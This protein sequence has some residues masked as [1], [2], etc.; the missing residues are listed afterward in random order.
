MHVDGFDKVLIGR[1]I[2]SDP[3]TYFWPKGLK[4]RVRRLGRSRSDLRELKHDKAS[5]WLQCLSHRGQ[6]CGLIGHVAKTKGHGDPV[7]AARLN[8]E[9]LCIR[10]D[11]PRIRVP[12]IQQSVAAHSDHFS[13]DIEQYDLARGPY[14]LLQ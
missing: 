7:N 9:L 11:E 13:I 12:L 4:K 8:G 6:C 1:S 10:D 14:T 2:A 5:A 3:P